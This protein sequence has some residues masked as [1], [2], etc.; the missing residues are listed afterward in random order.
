MKTLRIVKPDR[1]LQGSVSLPASKS[2][3]N[4]L[5]IMQALSGTDFPIVNLSKAYD[6]V[7]L[8]KLLNRIKASAGSRDAVELDCSDAGADLRFLTALLSVMPGRWVL[9]GSDRMKQ[10]PVGDLAESLKEL[11]AAIEYL[12]NVGFP[13]LLIKGRN[14]RSGELN[15]NAGVSS[16]FIS[17]LLMTA[18][19]LPEGLTLN[20]KGEMVSEPYIDMTVNLIRQCGIKAKKWK[21]KIRVEPGVYSCPDFTVEPDWSAASFWYQAAALSE[22]TDLLMP[23]LNENS[24]Q[25]DSLLVSAFS[26]FGVRSDFVSSVGSR[27]SAEKSEKRKAK[28]EEA[29]SLEQRT[30]SNKQSFENFAISPFRHFATSPFILHLTNN[31]I[32][33]EG[34]YYDFTHHPDLALPMIAC[35]AALGIRSRFEGLKSL[36]IKESDRV[37]SLTTE[38]KKLGCKINLIPGEFP[39]IEIQPSK[40]FSRPDI[41]IDTYRDHRMAMTFAMLAMKTG[42]ITINDPDVV[43]KSYP[44]FWEDLESAGFRLTPL[45]GPGRK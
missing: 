21:H 3:S 44:G 25:G 33:L 38:L 6:T 36:I 34:F 13:P 19:C 2:I 42:N 37:R 10:R 12:G 45:T 18:P 26:V 39:V 35:C 28:S 40:L 15:V 41:V 5:L 1:V 11:G 31:P 29:K 23:G 43:G 14:L 8:Q 16:Q 4:R 9:T 32:D 27:Q 17:A 30:M 7:L 20:L 24:L 22:K